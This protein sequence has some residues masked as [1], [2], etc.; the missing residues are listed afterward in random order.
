MT[1]RNVMFAQYVYIITPTYFD[2]EAMK[3]LIKNAI[4][5]AEMRGIITSQIVISI[6]KWLSSR[7]YNYL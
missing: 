2:K 3:S 1:I 7:P 5:K 4:E 6:T